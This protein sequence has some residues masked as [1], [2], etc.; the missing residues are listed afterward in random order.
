[1]NANRLTNANGHWTTHKSYYNTQLFG[2]KYSDYN[3]GHDYS[4]VDL[5]RDFKRIVVDGKFWNDEKFHSKVGLLYKKNSQTLK[6]I[7]GCTVKYY[8]PPSNISITWS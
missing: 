2:Y 4:W 3:L 7:M 1:M 8:N 5:K 6:H